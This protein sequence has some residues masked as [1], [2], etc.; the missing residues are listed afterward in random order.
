MAKRIEGSLPR[1][2]PVNK[3]QLTP[4]S[5]KLDALEKQISKLSVNFTKQAKKDNVQ[6]KGKPKKEDMSK[7]KCEHCDRFGHK[8]E[9]CFDLHPE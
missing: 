1:L 9:T 2:T 5:S 8:K 6:P 3:V 7:V 4:L